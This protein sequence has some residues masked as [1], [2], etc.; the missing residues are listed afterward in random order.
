M[1]NQKIRVGIVGAGQNTTSK[2]IPGLQAIENVEINSVCNR[3]Q[4]SSERVAA[5]FGIPTIYENWKDLIQADDTD[6]IVIGTWPYMHCQLTVA[7]LEAGKHVMC[8]ARMAMDVQQARQM[9]QVSQKY[10]ELI[11]Q[12][13]PSPMTLAV[14]RSIQHLICDGYLGDVLAIEVRAGNNFIDPNGVFHWRDN[15]DLSGLN[16]M[17]MGI[18]YEAVMRWVG[19]AKRISAMG[20]TFVKNRI[21]EHGIRQAVHVPDHIDVLADMACGAQ[22]HMQ[23]SSVAGLSGVA[24]VFLFG[25]DAT[26]RFSAGKLYGGTRDDSS[27][28]E[29]SISEDKIGY[30]RVEEEFINAIR[31]IETISHSTFDTGVKYMEFTE[32]VSRSLQSGRVVALPIL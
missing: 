18:W 10:P 25:S 3:S 14:D 22:L 6:A 2:H 15:V 9:Y 19:T 32:A 27:L 8:E 20:K 26:L 29:I 16:I 5:E 11:A 17:S 1:S 4:Q 30:W 7:S 13:V 12:I 23:I 21:D 24:E 28:N 31:G